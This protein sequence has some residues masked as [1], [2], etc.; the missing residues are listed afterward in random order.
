[1]TNFYS[2]ALAGSLLL[3]SAAAY[4]ATPSKAPKHFAKQGKSAVLAAH[5]S[6][7]LLVKA[8]PKKSAA[9]VRRAAR[10]AVSYAENNT[11][12]P[13][14]EV[15]SISLE[16]GEW[17]DIEKVSLTWNADGK[18]LTTITEGIDEEYVSREEM[19]YDEF[20]YWTSRTSFNGETLDA[21]QP[22][23]RDVRQYDP[24]VHSLAT[25]LATETYD[26]T[27]QQWVASGIANKVVITRDAAGNITSAETQAPYE[28]DFL[29][30]HKYVITY[31]ADGKASRIALMQMQYDENYKP[32][33]YAEDIVI[34]N[35]E[36]YTTDGQIYD[37]DCIFEGANK[38]KSFEQLNSDGSA[39]S[40][41]KVTYVGDS[42]DFELTTTYADGVF[43][44][45]W[46]DLENG[47]YLSHSKF[48]MAAEEGE[49]PYT[50]EYV[51]CLKLDKLGESLGEIAYDIYGG[52]L[53]FGYWTKAEETLND[54]DMPETYALREFYPLEEEGGE[55]YFAFSRAAVD[56]IEAPLEA[57]EG[58][59]FDYIK[60]AYSDYVLAGTNA[61]DKVASDIADGKAEYY[62]IDGRRLTSAPAAGLY[63]R[64]T[65]AGASKI[66]LK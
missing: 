38:V 24:R 1:M 64:R 7:N 44:Q 11:W 49:E 37:Q 15:V 60:I 47:G 63:I 3:G 16:P 8:S 20:G 53:E 28:G 42:D 39:L 51:E 61:I 65:A 19:A 12:R 26:A 33:G 13:S 46:T 41:T 4:A 25:Y 18:V 9:K 59:W 52:E 32:V 66:L 57:L 45:T 40:G 29:G 30:V 54:H 62:S 22:E 21:L 31:G 27:T 17:L 56:D 43:T 55:D 14:T 2:F 34:G 6:D 23:S 10:R 35:I 36:W 50:E 58:D 5:P 48:V